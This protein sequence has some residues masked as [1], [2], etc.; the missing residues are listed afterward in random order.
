MVPMSDGPS[1]DDIENLAAYYA[2]QKAR[3]VLYV[4]LPRK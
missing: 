1:E 4:P 3:A 2:H